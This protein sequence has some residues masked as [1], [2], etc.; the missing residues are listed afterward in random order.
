M[1]RDRAEVDRKSLLQFEADAANSKS[2]EPDV[3][4]GEVY[5]GFG[6]YE[7]A[8]AEARG[9]FA[10]LKEVPSISPWVLRLWQL[11]AETRL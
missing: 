9:A 7:H 5:F 11:Y 6:D 10:K 2:G 8:I 3:R 4:L 1:V